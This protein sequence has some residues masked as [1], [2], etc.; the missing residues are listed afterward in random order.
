[1]FKINIDNFH[2]F[3][4]LNTNNFSMKFANGYTVSLAMGTGMY[5]TGDIKNGFSSAEV[6]AWDAD[7]NWV[8]LGGIGN[9]VVG[10]QSPEQVLTIMNK[11]AAM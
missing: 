2:S 5:C 11:I 1:M 6:A 9:D 3:K 10:W 4:D 7:G 8:E